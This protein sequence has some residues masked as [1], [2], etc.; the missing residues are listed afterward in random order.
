MRALL[1]QW[2]PPPDLTVSEWAD[3]ERRLSPESGGEPGKYYTSR[4]EYAR[5]MMD[6]FNDPKVKRIVNMCS[7]QVG[8]ALCVDTEIPTPDGWLPLRDVHV[9]DTV[10][11]SDGMPTTVTAESEIFTDHE[12][13]RLTFDDGSTILADA[14]HRWEVIERGRS[15]PQI[16]TT[17]QMVG[18]L[19]RGRGYTFRVK[20][21]SALHTEIR[22]LPIPPYV[23]GAW[24]G[25]GHSKGSR[26]TVDRRD[27][28]IDELKR[29]VG[30]VWHFAPSKVN[31]HVGSF[32]PDHPRGIWVNGK[33]KRGH[34][35]TTEPD[36]LKY[37]RKCK[38]LRSQKTQGRI[39]DLTER[40]KTFGEV[41]SSLA[42]ISNK[43]IPDLYLRAS[44]DQRWALLQGLMDTDGTSAKNGNCSFSNTN[45]RLIAGVVELTA[46][47]GLKPKVI[48]RS[49]TCNGKR[50]PSLVV[51]FTAY[52]HQPV[53]RLT[54]KM[55]RLRDAASP[56]SRPTESLARSI[57]SIDKIAS[58]PVK[59]IAVDSAD[60]LYLAGRTMIPTHNTTVEENVIG[61]HV[62]HDPSP[63][64]FV[65]STLEVAE[66]MS[67]D[68]IAPMIRDTP[69]LKE[70]FA[71]EGSKT[72]GNTLLH[73]KF[74]GGHL[75]IAGANSYNSL[76]SRPIRIVL[77]DEA[78][79]WKPNEQ[80]S[81]F[82]QVSARTK[83]FWNSKTAF[84]S[85][86]TDPNTEFQ[87]I[88]DASDK[89]LFFV[90]CPH[91]ETSIVLCYNEQP[92]SLPT[93]SFPEGASK[94]VLKWTEGRPSRNEDGRE[95]RRADDAWFE[96]LHC[97]SRIEDVE[98]ERAVRRGFWIPT[99]EFH[100]TRGRWV[101]EAYAPFSTAL[102]IANE[103]LAA[104]G[105][106]VQMQSV[107]NET[108]GLP[109]RE[110]GAAPEWK[111]LFD[112]A[113]ASTYQLSVVPDGALVLTAGADVQQDRIEVQVVGW[114]RN[115]QCW[116]VDYIVLAGDTSRLEVWNDLTKILGTVYH[117]AK[118]SDFTIRKMAVDSGY[119]A[120]QVYDWARKHKFGPV[121]I[122]KGGPDTQSAM[123]AAPS[124][125][126]ITYGG[127]KLSTGL[128]LH[129]LNTGEF[130][131]ELYARLN[132]ESPNLE[133][134]EEYPSGFFHLTAL[135]DTEEYCRQLTAEHLVTHRDRKGFTRREWQKMRPRNEAL[136]TWVYAA[137]ARV[138]LGLDRFVRDEQWAPL[139]QQAGIV[140][141]QAALTAPIQPA[142]QLPAS[143][144]AVNQAMPRD[145][146]R[147][148][149]RGGGWF[150]NR[151]GSWIN[152]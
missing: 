24:L 150:G 125:I 27:G 136:D 36:S 92:E 83:R 5:A 93:E 108:F 56:Q 101:W 70:R 16:K 28:V 60:H 13:Y 128:K 78:A 116:L 139:E 35:R 33:C 49:S 123:V 87:E 76:A 117:N 106:P 145:A 94:A 140:R 32:V 81:P 64:M 62:H 25:D 103:W 40:K 126:E 146:F 53:F 142:A 8:K 66:S 97:G 120:N 121:A 132:L 48:E 91:C 39:E 85:T 107:K 59:C 46:S 23:L 4:T 118:G 129:N 69:A 86:P 141:Q 50:F 9:G 79:K 82:K 88:W 30:E 152:R 147:R 96:C 21:C 52:K 68:R 131:K 135:P 122:V 109:W 47:L 73:K 17:E 151:G 44:V 124:P 45:H 2:A 111:R 43:H 90:P 80:G 148:D 1:K 74:P 61:Y 37:C 10:F 3:A 138:M 41:L 15:H 58:V 112:R 34:D 144:P 20:C 114:G 115:R 130:K 133:R 77:G 143:A 14:G 57:V 100:G 19:R 55:N 134:G 65:T 67:K 149:I 127:K 54:R 72:S 71:S 84:F 29:E 105:N 31:P 75:T 6:D 12:C 38:V 104:L 18:A 98:R 22:V 42:L 51:R 113:Q 63:I 95:I 137:A 102:S 89:Q 7:A 99:A 119:A 110:Q 11:G 26:I